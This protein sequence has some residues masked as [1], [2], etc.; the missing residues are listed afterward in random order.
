VVTSDDRVRRSNSTLS[1]EG[2][3]ASSGLAIGPARVVDTRRPGIVHR[4]IPKHGVEE[5]MARF[6]AAVAVA[7]KELRMVAD[8]VRAGAARA[9][10]SIVEAYIMMVEDESLRDDVE[11]RVSIDRQC[12][13]WALDSAVREMADTLARSKDPYLAERSHDFEFIGDRI[14]RILAGPRGT[15]VLPDLTEPAVIIAHDL[16]PAETAGMSRE[17]VLAIVTEVGTRT[18]HTAIL[19]RA[20]EIPAVVGVQDILSYVGSSEQLIVD[21]LS[22]RVVLAPTQEM[23]FEAM[24]RAAR[25][26]AVTRGLRELRDKPA[27]T[28]CGVPIHLQANIELPGEANL[29]ML[30]GAEGIGLYRTEFMVVDPGEPPSEEEQYEIYRSVIEAVAPLPVTLRT[31]DLGGDKFT[32]LF[33][34]SMDANPALG[35]RAVRLGLARPEMFAPQLRAMLRASAHGSL[36]ILVPMVATLKELRAVRKLLDTARREV[37][38]AGHQQAEHVALGIMVEVPSAAV[39][40]DLFAAEAD[41]FSIGTNDLVQYALAVDRTSRAL[42]NLASPF[43]P[44]VLRLIRMTVVA[45]SRHSRPVGVCGAM[46]NDP[47]GAALLVGMGLRDLSMESSGIPQVKEALRRVSVAEVEELADRA[48]SCITAEEVKQVIAD[49]LAPRFADLLGA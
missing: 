3:A 15:T 11:R 14:L 12:V 28:Q 21:G 39:V 26:S 18:S 20:F 40:A 45:G 24:A 13:E 7:S 10:A 17:K 37:A 22:G 49:A 27:V 43:D 16:S 31:F 47:L 2:I 42:A 46:A 36:R 34:A 9:E 23:I 25:H 6:E 48:C 5:E 44:A 32:S 38:A 8:H 35:L 29:V 33:P 41:F 19:A 4:R 30:Q 1:L